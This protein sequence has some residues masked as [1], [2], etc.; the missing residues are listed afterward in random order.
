M[1]KTLLEIL[2]KRLDLSQYLFHFTKGSNA[3]STLRK[4]ISSESIIDINNNGYIC[5]SEAPLTSLSSMFDI[6]S[7]YAEPMYS[8][9]GIAI[10]RNFL[11][12]LGA[13]PVIYGKKEEKQLLDSTIQWRFVELEIDKSDYSW[14]REWRLNIHDFPFKDNDI[15]VITNTKDEAADITIDEDIEIDGD[16]IDKIPVGYAYLTINRMWK[17]ISIEEIRELSLMNDE[18]IKKLVE[19]QDIGEIS[20]HSLGT[21]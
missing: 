10:N 5:F 8:P 19:S 4:I 2:E 12:D 20:C 13:R 21:L 18:E 7:K 16:V 6:F 11:Y 17:S 14:L 1:N 9:Y 3:I 15:L